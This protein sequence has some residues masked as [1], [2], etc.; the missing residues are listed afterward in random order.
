MDYDNILSYRWLW[1]I[2]SIDK[3]KKKKSCSVIDAAN[4]SVF[5]D[6]LINP[7]ESAIPGIRASI[8]HP[9][10]PIMRSNRSFTDQ[11]VHGAIASRRN[12]PST[13][14][15]ILFSAIAFLP[16]KPSGSSGGR[17]AKEMQ[18][19]GEASHLPPRNVIT[20]QGISFQHRRG[21]WKV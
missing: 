17:A 8:P 9:Y 10:L 5:T 19:T 21:A 14:M 2:C 15:H 18:N 12:H 20:T 16:R 1:D 3:K 13:T 4:K 7:L 6:K 11:N